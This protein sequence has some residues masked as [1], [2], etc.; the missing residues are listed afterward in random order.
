MKIKTPITALQGIALTLLLSCFATFFLTSMTAPRS[1]HRDSTMI[2]CNPYAAYQAVLNS[3]KGDLCLGAALAQYPG[4]NVY[5]S[6][7]ETP[8]CGPSFLRGCTYVVEIWISCPFPGCAA[9]D[10]QVLEANVSCTFEV[11]S[12]NCFF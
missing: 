11:L 5:Y 4:Y 7:V 3:K 6:V 2:A 9:P 10:R 1:A 8:G 12:L